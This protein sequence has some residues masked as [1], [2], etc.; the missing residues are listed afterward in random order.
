M[1]MVLE[2]KPKTTK[3]HTDVKRGDIWNVDLRGSSGGVEQTGVRPCLVISNS[4]CNQYS[5]ALIIVPIS[6]SETKAKMPTH[7]E[8]NKKITGLSSPSIA[9]C[10]QIKTLDEYRFMEKIGKL[11]EELTLKINKAL[12]VSI[13]LDF[14]YYK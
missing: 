7:V 6:T 12:A 10:E 5:P 14:L 9:L 1:N 11:D 13:E 3:V 8:L 4:R 2:K